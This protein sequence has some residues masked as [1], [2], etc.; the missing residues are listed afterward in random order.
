MKIEC[1]TIIVSDVHLGT[2]GSKSKELV[3]FLKQYRCKNLILNGDIIDG[4]QLRKSGKWKRK[5]TRFFTK[6]LKM[7]EEDG[8]KIT[9]LRG[10]HDDFLDQVLPFTVGNLEIA[11]D[12]IYESKDRKYYI[13]HGDVFDSITSQFK[14]IAKLGDIGY[15]FLLWL[16]RQYNFRRMKKGLPYFSLS[17]KIKGKVK[18]AVKYIDDFETQLASMAK[19]KNCEGI[20]CGHIHQP[21]MK[22]IDGVHYMNSGDWVESMTALVEDMQGEWSLVYYTE[23]DQKEKQD[24]EAESKTIVMKDYFGDEGQESDLKVNKA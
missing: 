19:Y 8:T 11:R 16:N 24:K 7:I 4:W 14:W 22:M 17:Q 15:T 13:V 12:M 20:I 18:K 9:Y 23:S 2:K 3:R 21:A 1:K 5:H 10:N 6:I